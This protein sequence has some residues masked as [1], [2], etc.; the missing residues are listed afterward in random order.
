MAKD[1]TKG[2]DYLF[3]LDTAA[4]WDTPTWALI[5][6]VGD[7]SVDRVPSDVE[8]PERGMDT[9]HLQGHGDPVISFT[10]FEDKGDTNVEALIAAI[11]D[12]T[13]KHIAVS[14]GPI[15]T[16]A[17]KYWHM[18]SV[19]LGA[20]VSAGRGEP[21]SYEVEAKRHANSDNTLTRATVAGS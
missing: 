1:Y 9:G 6:A 10:L 14:R 17:N 5:K 7:L 12:G 16:A 19:L 4:D 11:H 15:A 3:Y 8:I 21:S 20:P 18:E 2:D 13:M